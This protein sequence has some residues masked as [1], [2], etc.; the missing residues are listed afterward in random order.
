M[1]RAHA[2]EI[3]KLRTQAKAIDSAYATGDSDLG[4]ETD[5]EFHR[6]LLV[7]SGSARLLGLFE[8]MAAHTRVLLL[9]NAQTFGQRPRPKAAAH[10][11]I[12]DAMAAG[13]EEAVE[14]AVKEHYRYRGDRLFT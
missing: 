10:R 4:L 5:L 14:R 11:K 12:V 1:A 2:D 13:S 3:T 6:Q 9:K 7:L 8:Q